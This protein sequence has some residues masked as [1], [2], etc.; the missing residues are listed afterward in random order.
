VEKIN[1]IDKKWDK[2][3]DDEIKSKTYEFKE[4]LKK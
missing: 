3:S 4:R 1:E 2:L